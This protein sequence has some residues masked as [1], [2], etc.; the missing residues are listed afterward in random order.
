MSLA[1]IIVLVIIGIVI[2]AV[3]SMR[4][5]PPDKTQPPPPPGSG[6]P[7]DPPPPFGNRAGGGK[8]GK[9]VGG[10]L[11]WAFGGPL[12]AILGFALGS[13]FDGRQYTPYKYQ[14]TPRDDFAMSLLVLSAAVMKADQK[15]VRSELDYVRNFFIA[16]FG[17]SEAA[18]LLL[19]L[20]EIL[21]QEIQVQDVSV[22]IGQY[23]DYHSRLQLLHYLF[24]IAS[25]DG[26]YHPDE[27]EVIETISRYMGISSADLTSI[28]AMFVK[29][30]SWAYDV[31]E[32]TSSATDDEIKKAYR[33]LAK[34]YHPDKVSH[35]GEDIR[36]SATEKFQNL[37]A[38]YEEIK[39]QRGIN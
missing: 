29:S 7:P 9:W 14:G 24:G 2:Y 15:I 37:N 32:V 33:E 1:T 19:V 11:G 18:R 17:E 26:Q 25:A 5:N 36:K 13:M 16:Q 34:K 3:V 39:R 12:G 30:I 28:R 10:G 6:T 20:R 27:L 21:K 8:Y 22:Q 4:R 38:A 23:M 31:L 35:L